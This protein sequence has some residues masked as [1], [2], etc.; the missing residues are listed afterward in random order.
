VVFGVAKLPAIVNEP[1]LNTAAF[2]TPSSDRYIDPLAVGM[3]T[4]LV[5][6]LIALPDP[7]EIPVSKEP[8]PIK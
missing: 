1:L 3:I 5:P 2:G 8:L 6:L 7:A 4:L